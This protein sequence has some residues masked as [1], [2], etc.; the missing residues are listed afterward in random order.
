MT[1]FLAPY[2][3]IAD[4]DGS[5]LDAGFIYIGEQGKNPEASPV[6]VFWDA[7]FTIPAAQPIRTRNGYPVR[8]G[9][10]AKIYLREPVHS[11]SVKNRNGSTIFV[12]VNGAGLVSTLLVRPNGETVEQTFNN[13][14][15]SLAEK[16]QQI[17]EK[18]PTEYVNEQLD[19]KAPQATTY[20]KTEVDSALA[21]K[22]P[23]SNTYTK[24]E[25]DA[26]LTAITGGH[27]AYATLADALANESTFPVNSIIEITN[28]PN[29]SNN[30]T[31]LWDG[32]DLTKSDYD[33]LT[34]AKADAT[35]KATAAEKNAIQ[36]ADEKISQFFTLDFHIEDDFSSVLV[37]QNKNIL[38]SVN[39]EGYLATNNTIR[40]FY[41][42]S[43]DSSFLIVSLDDEILFKSG[44]EEENKNLQLSSKNPPLKN[45]EAF[46]S[47]GFSAIAPNTTDDLYNLPVSAL[48][49][50]PMVFATVYSM[51]DELV[52]RFDSMSMSVI[53]LDG[54]GDEIRQYTYTPKPLI[55]GEVTPG[56]D[57]TWDEEDI[58]PLKIVITTGV[59]GVERDAIFN[60]YLLIKEMLENT[61]R[62]ESML[63]I[64][65]A[66]IVIIPVITPS[67]VRNITRHNWRNIDVN[68][69]GRSGFTPSDI[70]GE[71]ALDQEEAALAVSLPQ[72]HP[73]AACFIDHH[74]FTGGSMAAWAS[75]VNEDTLKVLKKFAFKLNQTILNDYP[76]IADKPIRLGKNTNGSL[77]RDWQVESNV[78]AY[79]IESPL[80]AG[81][82]DYPIWQNRQL[83]LDILKLSLSEIIKHHLEDY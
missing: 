39:K 32:V 62:S 83:G 36:F 14:D 73:D 50:A 60:L 70:N 49:P 11:I 48:L 35:V 77:A 75:T 42:E 19:L 54:R 80:T 45:E 52:S 18:A 63:V 51:Y 16:Q 79:L 43:T 82:N 53:G 56:G 38:L 24:G 65:Q 46:N 66:K 9:S 17:N 34:Q 1:M 61:N 72:L 59:H 7:D 3:A 28:D 12:D 58:A 15:A 78:K 27:K 81:G 21:L 71:V 44:I 76:H 20:T 69:N 23:Q 74:N 41:K 68:R 13:I 29:P 4:I 8:N 57:T 10:P 22:A 25:V 47:F 40:D 5:P 6:S 2:T 31:Y 67:G 64:Q 37:D 26:S 55:T 30:G 33:P